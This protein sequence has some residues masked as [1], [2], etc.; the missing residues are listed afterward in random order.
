MLIIC[1]AGL[2]LLLFGGVIP[3]AKQIEQTKS[4]IKQLDTALKE[5]EA[6]VPVYA[7]LQQQNERTT[8][9]PL[10]TPAR[11]PLLI[12]SL[13]DL[14]NLFEGMARDAGLQLVSATP[15]VR[16]LRDG[17]EALRMDARVRGEYRNM[18]ALL[19]L[20][21]EL[22]YIE[23]IEGVS[24]DVVEAGKEMRLTIWLGIG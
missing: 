18:K 16:S 24:V 3:A 7:M 5:H 2:L 4:E 6:L 10:P 9:A 19:M 14:P 12:E 8:L 21:G 13:T 20:L 22:P 1:V 11:N 17:N 23:R 15:Q